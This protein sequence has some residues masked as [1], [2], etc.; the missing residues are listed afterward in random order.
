MVEA[1]RRLTPIQRDVAVI[2]GG[3]AVLLITI[4]FSV[5]YGAS[6]GGQPAIQAWAVGLIAVAGLLF[7]LS[8]YWWYNV[9]EDERAPARGEFTYGRGGRV[10]GG[11]GSFRD[12][13]L[14]AGARRE[15]ES[16]MAEEP[17]FVPRTQARWALWFLG[18]AASLGLAAAMV[19]GATGSDDPAAWLLA[20]AGLLGAAVMLGAVGVGEFSHQGPWA[21]REPP[22]PRA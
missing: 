10:K 3:L 19:Q 1:F 5:A 17:A 13:K 8:A 12:K 16:R 22:P 11:V 18:M 20:A 21:R 14:R 2:F 4:W 15:P 7:A 9:Y 6:F